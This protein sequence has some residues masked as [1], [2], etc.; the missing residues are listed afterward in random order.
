MGAPRTLAEAVVTKLN[1][2]T[3]SP[4]ITFTK[5]L[6]PV[7]KSEGQLLEGRVFLQT[8]TYTKLDRCSDYEESVDVAVLVV[9]PV[10]NTTGLPTE[11][12]LN[13]MVDLC[14]SII[15]Y[16]KTAGKL[17]GYNLVEIE[18]AEL[19]DFGRVY[20]ESIFETTITLRYRGY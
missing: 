14:E 11:S 20:E 2:T 8:K 1:A 13:S 15:D 10:T 18:Q 16:M 19:F 12:S 17:D 6:V 7:L 5:T 4:A 3:F 9:G